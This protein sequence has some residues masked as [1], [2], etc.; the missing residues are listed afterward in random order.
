MF[1]GI[2]RRT[3]GRGGCEDESPG[4]NASKID[5]CE[6]R[7]YRY[8]NSPSISSATVTR[9]LDTKTGNLDEFLYKNCNYPTQRYHPV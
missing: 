7:K 6:Y 5:V 1:V 9:Q 2:Y 3:K 8:L 4:I